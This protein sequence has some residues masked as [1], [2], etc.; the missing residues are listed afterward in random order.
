MA[1][2]RARPAGQDI[3]SVSLAEV[4]RV[5]Y[6]ADHQLAGTLQNPGFPFWIAGIE[7][8][9]GQRPPTPPLDMLTASRGAELQATGDPLWKHPGI[10]DA[11]AIDGWDG[12][13]P[14]FTVDGFSAGGEAV[15]ALTRL[16]FSREMLKAK[17]F[18]FPEE[19]TDIEQAAMAFHALRCHD[20]SRPNGDAAMCPEADGSGTDGFG[21][22][23]VLNG[24][25]PVPGA[26]MSLLRTA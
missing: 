20:T 21:P 26:L 17:P 9:V 15:V 2:R 5:T 10:A 4:P 8:S 22:G 7:H 16:D 1:T 14:R 13:L 18:F 12:G 11:D 23:F 3:L 19:G 6:P 25:P 24:A